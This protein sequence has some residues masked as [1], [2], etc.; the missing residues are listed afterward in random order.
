MGPK[1]VCAPDALHRADA[2][3]GRLGH[4]GGDPVG[5]LGGRV[6]QRQ[7]DHPLGHLRA[8]RRDARWPCLVAQQTVVALLGEALLPA[9]DAG[10]RLA[11]PAHDPI[12]ADAISAGSTIRARQTCFWA[13]LRSPTSASRRRRSA[14]L[15]IDA[16]SWAHEPARTHRESDGNPPRDSNVRFYPLGLGSSAATL[17]NVSRPKDH[18]LLRD[19]RSGPELTYLLGNV[20]HKTI[21]VVGVVVKNHER[22]DLSQIAQ[23]HPLLPGRMTPALTA[24]KGFIRV[25]R[26]VDDDVG[27]L[28]K[29]EDISIRGFGVVFGVGQIA[30]RL[31]VEVDPVAG[32]VVGMVKR[33]SPHRDTGFWRDRF[34]GVEIVEPDLGLKY[35]ER[36]RE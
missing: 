13:T 27:T 6:A 12:G 23:T 17:A 21:V 33:R 5:R 3:A 34:A 30:D 7:G 4:H 10:L 22:L 31:A 29:V 15:E 16:D 19:D 2:D 11:G 1:P 20:I 25:H 35:F 18:A 9:P 24:V 28:H 26:I 36:H 8:E 32:C 14:G